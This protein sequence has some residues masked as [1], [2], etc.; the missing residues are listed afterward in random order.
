MHAAYRRRAPPH[1]C[2][3]HRPAAS[4]HLAPSCIVQ[5]EDEDEELSPQ[6]PM[7]ESERAFLFQLQDYIKTT[8]PPRVRSGGYPRADMRI[9]A[10]ISAPRGPPRGKFSRLRRTAPAGG[11]AQ[12]TPWKAGHAS[13]P[14]RELP[15][16]ASML[17]RAERSEPHISFH[18]RHRTWIFFRAPNTSWRLLR[19]RRQRSGTGFGVTMPVWPR[20]SSVLI[21]VL[22]HVL[23]D[24]T[25]MILPMKPSQR[26]TCQRKPALLPLTSAS[27]SPSL[28]EGKG[29]GST[30]PPAC[31]GGYPQGGGRS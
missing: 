31:P 25:Y 20:T 23:Q 22:R 13:A 15:P 28:G 6:H 24:V 12:T 26:P 5:A 3:H 2:T 11:Y 14:R 18:H 30:P 27:L 4:P 29:R 16:R 9:S 21:S 7:L 19:T 17:S 10:A 8:P 1:A